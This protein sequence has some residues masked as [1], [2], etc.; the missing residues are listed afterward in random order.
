[1]CLVLSIAFSVS[2]TAVALDWPQWRGPNRDGK[3]AGFTAP[4]TWPQEL[5]QKWKV[6]VGDGVSTPALVGDRLYVFSREE[7]NEVTRCLDADAGREIWRDEYEAKPADGPAG[8]FP[9]PRSS[10]TVAD[11]KV[12]T[13]GVR[14]VLSCLDAETGKVLWRKSEYTDSLPRFYTSS[15]PIVVNGNCIA[16]L[17]GE[18]TGAIVAYDLAAGQETWKWTGDGTAYASPVVL[19]MDDAS[20]VIAETDDNIVGLN[21]ATGE[22]TWETPYAVSGR[23]YNAATPILDGQKIIYTGSNR[24]AIAAEFSKQGD[25]LTSRELWNNQDN[26]VQYNSPVLKDGLLYGLSKS[27]ILFCINTETGKTLWTDSVLAD[28]ARQGGEEGGQRQRAEGRESRD[29]QPNAGGRRS[30]GRRGGGGGGGYGSIVDAG[31]VLIALTPAGRLIVFEPSA[32]S[33]KQIASYKVA[34]EGTY[35]YPIV[36]GN[37]VFVKDADSVTL[38]SIE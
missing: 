11:G 28:D 35:A 31:S 32:E 38:W 14:G 20:I 4:A 23:G 6:Q 12:I 34:A 7:G 5:S 29:Q 24:G 2:T 30:G 26:S 17:G 25:S 15:S 16:Q 22:V 3:A 27:N 8:R 37:R 13:Y 36:A 1:M 21:A 10:P 18:Q 9:G 19:R 33:F